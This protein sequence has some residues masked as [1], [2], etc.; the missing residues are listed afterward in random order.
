M[1]VATKM[2]FIFSTHFKSLYDCD[3]NEITT[4]TFMLVIFVKIDFHPL[5]PFLFPWFIYLLSSSFSSSLIIASW[6]YRILLFCIRNF[7]QST[8]TISFSG[9]MT[10]ILFP[11]YES[12]ILENSCN[13]AFQCF[14]F[15]G[16]ISML[17]LLLT[18]NS[19]F[20]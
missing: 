7:I 14:P 5:L 8:T 4:H 16:W 20:R 17:T 9:Q 12:M 2:H 6:E 11:D 15:Y 18:F 3:D 10:T 19:I 1:L 13:W